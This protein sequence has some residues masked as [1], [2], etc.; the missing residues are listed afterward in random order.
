M[1]NYYILGS[2]R[3]FKRFDKAINSLC[4]KHLIHK[5]GNSLSQN[6]TKNKT[7][8][9]PRKSKN[10]KNFRGL[11]KGSIQITPR[12]IGFVVVDE[13]DEDIRVS[14]RDV[15]TSLNGDLVEVMIQGVNKKQDSLKERLWMF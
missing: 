5:N 8:D 13:L 10:M 15:S 7:S 9:L 3:E 11:M 4:A 6:S 1:K 12:G 2:K 14:R